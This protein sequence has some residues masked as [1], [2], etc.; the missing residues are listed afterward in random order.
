MFVL[1]IALSAL[2]IEPIDTYAEQQIVRHIFDSRKMATQYTGSVV[3][4]TVVYS[5]ELVQLGDYSWSVVHGSDN[6]SG[7]EFAELTD[8]KDKLRELDADKR[9]T[10]RRTW[11]ALGLGAPLAAG[12]TLWWLQDKEAFDDNR[13]GQG[14]IA[15]GGVG[16]LL[17]VVGAGGAKDIGNYL[18]GAYD[19]DEADLRIRLYNAALAQR[20][21]LDPAEASKQHPDVVMHRS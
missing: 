16:V 15:V 11:I 9:K 2:A 21:G 19:S 20:L 7:W 1:L 13:L 14:M 8:D 3:G 18:P 5:P 4:D 10:H 17:A 12:G 6:L